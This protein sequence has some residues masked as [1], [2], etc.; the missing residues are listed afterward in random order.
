[1]KYFGIVS[2]NI[3]ANFTNYGSALQSWAL[4]QTIDNLGSDKWKAK[5]I[6]YCPDILKDKDPLN[7]M[8]NMW[9]KD[10][11]MR[12]ECELSLPAIKENYVKFMRFYNEEFSKTK[13]SYTS[14]DFNDVVEDE[15]ISGFVCGSDTIFC[16][17]EFGID[18]GYYANYDC[19]KNGQTISYAASFG[20]PHFNEDTYKVLN[21][22]LQNF[23]AIG[24]RENNMLEYVK[25]HTN[26]NVQKVLDPTLILNAEDYEKITAEKLE[27]EKY[28]LLYSR[29]YNQNMYD[30][31][32]KIAKENG[33][34]IIEISLQASNAS[35]HRMFYEA[36]V[37]EFLSLVKNAE[38]IVTNSFHGMIF[39]VQF[40]RQFVIFSR[41]QCSTK[42]EELLKLFGLEDRLLIN[43]SEKFNKNID[44]IKV[45]ERI[46]NER[47]QSIKFLKKELNNMYVEGD[48][49]NG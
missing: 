37:E 22:R 12:K 30:F 13:K 18:D 40:R 26:V 5:L 20:D 11:K 24:L 41:E 39:A 44:Y 35:K 43:G 17:D 38:F 14:S 27:N 25:K 32:E 21:D 36:G 10:E 33:W 1:M 3:Y 16:V 47:I 46:N 23:K 7:P 49:A 45:H 48:K 9:D 19:M 8:K 31:A 28:L 4:S 15:N 34:R 42:I 6:D 29:R 2:Y